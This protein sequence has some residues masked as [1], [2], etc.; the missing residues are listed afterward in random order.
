MGSVGGAN[1]RHSV[2]GST[3]AKLE[4]DSPQ[5]NIFVFKLSLRHIYE[6]TRLRRTAYAVCR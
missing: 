1:I 6:T 3:A 4:N 5:E 2:K